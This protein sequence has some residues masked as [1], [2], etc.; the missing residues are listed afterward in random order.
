MK[1]E[2]IGVL[3]NAELTMHPEWYTE[4][5]LMKGVTVYRGIKRREG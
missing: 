3:I 4:K 1:E 5:S 2:N